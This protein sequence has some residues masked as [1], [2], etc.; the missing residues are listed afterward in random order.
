MQRT[1]PYDSQKESGA[2]CVP[3][4][5]GC[6]GPSDGINACLDVGDGMEDALDAL[7]ADKLREHVHSLR[8]EAQFVAMLRVLQAT[9]PRA[10]THATPSPH[11]R[12]P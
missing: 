7:G 8:T 5:G 2:R 11:P 3:R 12:Q 9:L 4:C 6:C 10:L 1:E